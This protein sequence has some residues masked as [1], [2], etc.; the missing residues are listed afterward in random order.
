ME[1]NI[2]DRCT[3]SIICLDL[4]L[5]INYFNK[6]TKTFFKD[7]NLGDNIIKLFEFEFDRLKSYLDIATQNPFTYV[8]KIKGSYYKT[9][10]SIL[11]DQYMLEIND[12]ENE[13]FFNIIN[14]IES[15]V[16]LC[17]PLNY[18]LIYGNENFYKVTGYEK[19]EI[20]GKNLSLLKVDNTDEIQREK[21]KEKLESKENFTVVLKNQN[22][23]GSIYYNKVSVSPIKNKYTNRIQFYLG[24]QNDVTDETIENKYFKAVLNNSKSIMIVNS[25]GQIK[26]I[27]KRFFEIFDYIDLKD[28]TDKHNCICEL[29]VKKDTNYVTADMNGIPWHEY[30]KENHDDNLRKVCMID[31]NGEERIFQID[32]SGKLFEYADDE[33]ITLSEITALIKSNQMLKDQSKHAMMGEMIAMIAHQW[34]QPLATLNTILA[35]INILNDMGMLDDNEFKK[36]YSK[37]TEIIQHLSNTI[38]DFRNFFHKNEKLEEIELNN[39]IKKSFNLLESNFKIKEISFDVKYIN[40]IENLVIKVNSSKM[41]Q[42]LINLIK[43]AYDELIK[44][45]IENKKVTVICDKTKDKVFISVMD[46]AGGIPEEIKDKIFDPYFSTKSKNGTGLGLY[47]SKMIVED[48]MKGTLTVKN[49]SKG[50]MFNIVIPIN[51]DGELE[52]E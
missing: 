2:L 31:K 7:V 3:S 9:L 47:M 28:F 42:V 41:T 51:I 16:V 29:F 38:D 37:S 40:H 43:N 25:N 27:N 21:L 14:N 20:I 10:I 33:L 17:D 32:S 49:L 18:N 12:I 5:N 52:N 19:E 44:H 1:R 6:S 46:N 30:I 34:R 26:N 36:A 22:K 23:N 50:A 4:Q 8:F 39:L 45:D 13:F 24:T 35:K 11:N 15:G 48:Q